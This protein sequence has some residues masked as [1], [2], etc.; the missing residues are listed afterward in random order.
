MGLWDSRETSLVE[1]SSKQGIYIYIYVY[2]IYI[3]IYSGGEGGTYSLLVNLHVSMGFRVQVHELIFERGDMGKNC[4][5]KLKEASLKPV[6]CAKV[7]VHSISAQ[8]AGIL[9]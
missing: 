6:S 7:D 5:T 2:Y 8:N 3:Y 9:V 4:R 1:R